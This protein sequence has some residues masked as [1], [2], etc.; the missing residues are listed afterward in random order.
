MNPSLATMV[1]MILAS[2]APTPGSCLLQA[3]GSAE[4]TS[5]QDPEGC[6]DMIAL[7]HLGL[8]PELQ[9]D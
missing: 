3:L 7:K 6:E 5:D 4:K 8:G 2:S 9:C 1:P